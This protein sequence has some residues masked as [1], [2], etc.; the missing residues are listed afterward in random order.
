MPSSNPLPHPPTRGPRPL[1]ILTVS[2]SR[3]SLF[4]NPVAHFESGGAAFAFE[5]RD[6]N[7]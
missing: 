7:E 5:W 1:V 2:G 6:L 3:S 4:S